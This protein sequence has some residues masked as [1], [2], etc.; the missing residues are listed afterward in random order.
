MSFKLIMSKTDIDKRYK[1]A[2]IYK[3]FSDKT[4]LI[5]IGS[6]IRTLNIRLSEHKLRNKKNIK[7]ILDIDPNLKIELLESYPC[8]NKNELET[9]ERYYIENNDCVN[10]TIP[11]RSKNE[12]MKE[13]HNAHKEQINEQKSK[14]YICECSSTITLGCKARHLRTKKHLEFIKNNL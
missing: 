14:T 13:Y 10:K 4:D 12:Y 2:K 9:R 5:Y 6:T 3:I 8:K 11:T 1:D 7:Q